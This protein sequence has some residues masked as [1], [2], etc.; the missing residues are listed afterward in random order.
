MTVGAGGIR[1]TLSPAGTAL[2][3]VTV[4]R[5]EE[6]EL[7]GWWNEGEVYSSLSGGKKMMGTH[8]DPGGAAGV[9][10]ALRKDEQSIGPLREVNAEAITAR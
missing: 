6:D 8:G 3:T 5:C 10:V 4:L 1:V 9:T 2:Q 7:A